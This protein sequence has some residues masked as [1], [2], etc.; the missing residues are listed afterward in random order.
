MDKNFLGKNLVLSSY[1]EK[2]DCIEHSQQVL[3]ISRR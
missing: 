3:Y 1:Q 2:I